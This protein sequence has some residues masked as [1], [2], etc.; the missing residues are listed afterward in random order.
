MFMQKP[1]VV[2]L[3]L[4]GSATLAARESSAE[5]A[6]M[7]TVRVEG[8]HDQG[9]RAQRSAAASALGDRALIDT[10]FSINVITSEVIADQQ[11]RLLLEVLRNDPSAVAGFGSGLSSVQTVSLRGYALAFDSNYRRDGLPFTHFS[12]TPFE[13]IE[14]VDVLKGL[15]GFLYGFA[16]PG[17]II[18]I[19]PKKP[20][21]ETFSTLH[22]GYSSDSLF[23]LHGDAGGRF[24]MGDQ[25]GYRINMAVERGEAAINDVDIERLVGSAYF[26]WQVSDSLTLALDLEAHRRS[27]EGQPLYYAVAPGVATPRPPNLRRFNGIAYATYETTDSLVGLRADWRFAENWYARASALDYRNQRDAWFSQGTILNAE[28]DIEVRTQRDD[29]QKFPAQSAELL[30]GGTY[31]SGALH[32]EITL[33]ANLN[34]R[35]AFRGD[36]QASTIHESNL[37]APVEAPFN[38][39][40]AARARY[41][42]ATADEISYFLSDTVSIGDRVQLMAGL[43]R[44]RLDQRNFN[45]EGVRTTR[46]DR[47]ATTPSGALIFKPV[48]NLA[49]YVSYA[50]GLEPGGIAPIAAANAS[51]VFAPLKS[52]QIEAG[53]K[54]EPTTALAVNVAAFD[55]DKG[56]SFTDPATNRFSQKGRQVHRG[57]EFTAAGQM[58]PGLKFFA[59]TMWLDAEAKRTG[60]AAIN[61]GRPVNAPEWTGNFY[62][63]YSIPALPRI[64]VN[65]GLQ[66]VGK[67]QAD[68]TNTRQVD[69]YTLVNIGTRYA[70]TLGGRDV[71]LRA[72]IDNVTG[73]DY[74]AAAT[75]TLH[76][77]LPR[78]IKLSVH[79]E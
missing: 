44:T 65:A 70:L 3:L 17:G 49:L 40:R 15:G 29:L 35:E 78:T 72:T 14:R 73:K 10:P 24:G 61:G 62:V 4:L 43:R 71:T 77:G 68:A 38:D 33:G 9:Y 79:I 51:E 12:E 23:A 48:G 7:E 20:T 42:N 31:H 47:G 27:P 67:R 22:A 28:G 37:Y 76:G 2:A 1:I 8:R 66:Y 57:M 75:P 13:T 54:W 69:A 55:I 58:R 11:A 59:G 53:L 50:E 32:H 16:S 64:A 46:Y 52:E 36:Y 6:V 45:A 5:A 60:N 39:L 41:R 26:D 30:I 63:D 25:Y 18:N 74:W 21:D 34:S 19:V 56:L